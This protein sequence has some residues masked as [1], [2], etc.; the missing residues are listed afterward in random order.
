MVGTE[1]YG[2]NNKLMKEKM[3]YVDVNQHIC[4]GKT[5][6]QFSRQKILIKYLTSFPEAAAMNAFQTWACKA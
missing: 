6:Q 2:P 1:R 4:T 3:C 5:G